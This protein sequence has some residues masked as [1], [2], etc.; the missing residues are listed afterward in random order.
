MGHFI[1][2][3]SLSSHIHPGLT[4]LEPKASIDKP[5]FNNQKTNPGSGLEEAHIPFTTANGSLDIVKNVVI[6]IND[7][8]KSN[9]DF[10]DPQP[11]A[12]DLRTRYYF[13]LND[14]TMKLVETIASRPLTEHLFITDDFSY[15]TDYVQLIKATIDKTCTAPTASPVVTSTS[16]EQSKILMLTCR[17][18]AMHN[19]P[20][21]YN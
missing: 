3:E 13:K 9:P 19:I 14:T 4:V 12:T 10:D 1:S 17:S 15:M 7:G 6:F 5:P 21:Y 16:S 18:Q 2:S 8:A 20:I 11:I